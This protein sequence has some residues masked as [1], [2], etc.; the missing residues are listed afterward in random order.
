MAQKC[1][2]YKINI[3]LFVDFLKDSQVYT[4]CKKYHQNT[5]TKYFPQRYKLT[6]SPDINNLN[7]TSTNTLL[8]NFTKLTCQSFQYPVILATRN[9]MSH[10]LIS[11][12]TL[13]RGIF[14]FRCMCFYNS[15]SY[16]SRFHIQVHANVSHNS[17]SHIVNPL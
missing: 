17:Q 6:K 10:P 12:E 9:S 14:Q 7:I 2:V 4:V 1:S 16:F 11:V 3:Q 8:K 5:D 15:S 13:V